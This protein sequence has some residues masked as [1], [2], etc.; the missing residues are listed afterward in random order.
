MSAVVA[1]G[2]RVVLLGASNLTR[3]ISTVVATAQRVW[4]QPLEVL[5]ALGHGRS[6]GIESR[7]LGRRLPGILNSGLWGTLDQA[8]PLPTAVLITDV[9]NDILYGVPVAEIVR[10]VETALD[11]L[12]P[13]AK[14]CMTGLPMG[15]VANLGPQRF[16]LYRQLFFP[17]C[18]LSLE[19]ARRRACELHDSLQSIATARHLGWIELQD[20]WYGIDPI[21]IQ[22]RHWSRAWAEMLSTWNGSHATAAAARASMARWIYLRTRRPH[23]RVLFGIKQYREQPSATL[24]DG[25]AI[26]FY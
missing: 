1:P 2:R 21:H 4:G 23:E 5:A 7:V 11:R 16:R 20:H 18:R 17:K 25:T 3:G 10:W 26:S 12:G 6:Y 8:A 24:R 14:I 9:G 15:S 19:E 22:L 13:V